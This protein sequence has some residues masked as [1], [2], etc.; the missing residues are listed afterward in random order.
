MAALTG[1]Q[2]RRRRVLSE[3][4]VRDIV[5]TLIERLPETHTCNWQLTPE[6]VGVLKRV[7]KMWNMTVTVVGTAIVG[8]I[9]AGVLALLTKG[10]W[11]AL[12]EGAKAS[13][14]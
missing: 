4:D 6:D 13:G 8:S 11:A 3:D 14:K 10:F 2:E 1:E 12:W 5:D 7:L 9:V